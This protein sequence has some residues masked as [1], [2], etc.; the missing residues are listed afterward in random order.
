M[1]AFLV[2]LFSVC[3][4]PA[5]AIMARTSIETIAKEL[6]VLTSA[7][8]PEFDKYLQR[9][10]DINLKRPAAILLPRTENECQKAVITM[11]NVTQKGWNR[12]LTSL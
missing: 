8:S 6:R 9:W 11:S 12:V 1:V 5:L 4:F 10:S 7:N 2:L 3:I